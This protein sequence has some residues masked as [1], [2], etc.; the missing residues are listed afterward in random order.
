MPSW[1]PWFMDTTR[2][3]PLER[4]QMLVWVLL[5]IDRL[6]AGANRIEIADAINGL[7]ALATR[8]SSTTTRVARS[9]DG[10]GTAVA[11][12]GSRTKVPSQSVHNA[13]RVITAE[14]AVFFGT[15]PTSG[16]SATST[17]ADRASI[18][19]DRRGRS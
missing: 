10:G 1:F 9:T 13:S 12:P 18:R 17:P 4:E 6:V 14:R 5:G 8:S 2:G 19:M 15:M 7:G 3:L 11:L 16:C